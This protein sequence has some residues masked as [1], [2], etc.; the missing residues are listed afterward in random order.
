M[1]GPWRRG[2]LRTVRSPAPGPVVIKF[3]GSLFGR[4][5][6]PV[7]IERLVAAETAPAVVVVGGG[8]L[9]DALRAIDAVVTQP[10]ALMHRLAIDAMGLTARLVAVTTGWSLAAEVASGLRPAATVLDVPAWL[11]RAGRMEQLPASWHVTSDS[12]AALVATACGGRL[13]LAKSVPPPCAETDLAALAAC[14]WV[15]AHFPTAAAA[16][17]TLGWAAPR[18]PLLKT[19]SSG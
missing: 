9:V 5:D 2:V 16:L 8:P 3:G 19:R 1:N 13:L 18:H 11:A 10:P 17:E 12:I 7:L 15:D 6:W 14:G 4:D